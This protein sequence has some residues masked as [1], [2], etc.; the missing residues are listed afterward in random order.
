[1][2]NTSATDTDTQFHMSS[3]SGSK[4]QLEGKTPTK[5]D[6][7]CFT[8]FSLGGEAWCFRGPDPRSEGVSQIWPMELL[9]LELEV[10][11]VSLAG[12]LA[13]VHCSEVAR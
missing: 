8:Q 10:F 11:T 12:S 4:V 6:Q 1:M 3:D 7:V 2:S 5:P 13:V 9:E